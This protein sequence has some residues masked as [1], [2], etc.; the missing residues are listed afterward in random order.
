MEKKTS[1]ENIALYIKKHWF[2][3]IIVSFLL[4]V[5]VRK[6]FSFQFNMNNPDNVE[7]PSTTPNE[8]KQ[9]RQELI[10]QKKTDKES[11][12]SKP[13]ILDRF[14]ISF[15]GGGTTSNPKSEYSKMDE[16]TSESY[17]KRFAHVA[18][19]ERKKYGV[20][21]S[22]IL[23]NGLLHS[24]AGSRD[25]AQLGH[26][27]FAISCSSDWNGPNGNYQNNCY[28]HYENAWTSFRDHSL[29]VTSGK[30]A[31]LLQLGTTDY[32]AWAKGLEKNGFSEFSGLEKNLVEIIEKFELYHLDYQ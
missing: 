30:Y 19:S 18:I 25:M 4:F 28:R 22:I 16:A 3:F 24:F 23:A 21:S 20:P 14:G 11:T 15:I 5:L 13:G 1:S 2:Q 6:D 32:K 9:K 27:H 29:F 31:K 10:T 12:K 7:H 26:N 8:N 17:L